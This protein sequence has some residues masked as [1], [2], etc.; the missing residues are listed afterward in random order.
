[1]VLLGE[2]SFVG[3]LRMKARFFYSAAI[4]IFFGA[5]YLVTKAFDLMNR[6]SNAAVAGGALIILALFVLVP[7]AL[8]WVWHHHVTPHGRTNQKQEEHI[9][10]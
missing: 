4:L 1:V 5:M 6:P 7:S 3:G 9:D 10:A 2:G 8:S